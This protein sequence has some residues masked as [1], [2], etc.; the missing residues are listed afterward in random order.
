MSG[1]AFSSTPAK[2]LSGASGGWTRSSSMTIP[3]EAILGV[4]EIRTDFRA[5]RKSLVIGGSV[6]DDLWDMRALEGDLD[7]PLAVIAS[8]Y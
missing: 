3:E 5:E 4:W 7:S 1:R 2:L 6:T 8:L